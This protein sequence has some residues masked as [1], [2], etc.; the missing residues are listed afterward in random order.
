MPEPE[1]AMRPV[2]EM[3]GIV[4]TFGSTQALRGVDFMVMPGEIHALL[5]RNGA[6]KSTLV[7]TLSG[8]TPA[9]SGV[10]RIG[11]R[12]VVAA[13][14]DYATTIRDG[15]A[16]V[17]QTPQLFDLLSVAEN[18]LL[19]H[20][21]MRNRSG[22]VS[23]R[24]MMDAA[25]EMLR[26]WRMDLRPDAL[27]GELDAGSRQLLEI[28]KALFRGVPV[29]ILDEPTAALSSGEKHMLFQH[30]RAL[31]ERGVSFVYISHH[32]S[33]V[34]DVA[35]CVT[36]LRDG[37]VV[38][39]R[40]PVGN[41]DLE[42]LAGL[43]MGE[44][45]VRSSRHDYTRRG[46]PALMTARE[47]RIRP[48]SPDTVG[49]QL[50]PGEIVALAGPVGGGKESLALALAG[51][52]PAERSGTPRTDVAPASIGF[53]PNDRHASGY[54]GML[55]IRENIAIGGLDVLSRS[56]GFIDGREE[57]RL[58]RSLST[59]TSVVASSLD[60]PVGQLSGGN[61]QKVVF[62]R[63]L[64]RDPKVMVAMSPT[65]G[66]DVGAKEQLYALLRDMARR[67]LGVIVVSD[68]EDEIEQL[69]NRVVILSDGRIVD[70]LTGDYRMQDL[71]LH[72]E[73]SA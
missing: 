39:A 62:A 19:E 59:Q 33:E 16:H 67:G 30:V 21:G 8:I 3:R 65:R 41:L 43:M 27:A 63:A 13:G 15:I 52:Q 70:E 28:M 6:G 51:Q 11:E 45:T 54:V 23:R 25:Q 2:V 22:F 10:I 44:K 72:M 5:G 1:P 9:D 46:E 36:V 38:R 12:T 32:L 7:S 47:L 58:A 61:Q 31:R 68:E 4:K 40:D 56:S 55:G 18:L 26:D 35:D 37:V 69:A 50:W 71:V 24:R 14:V 73:G 29:I 48:P 49:F 42:T 53:V 20:G 17:Q 60:Q 57:V 64:C 34:F 66:V